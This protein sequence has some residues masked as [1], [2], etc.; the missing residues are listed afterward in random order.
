VS[1]DLIAC[2]ALVCSFVNVAAPVPGSY[3]LTVVKSAEPQS[4]QQFDFT[5]TGQADFQLNDPDNPST[6]FR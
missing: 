2:S 5:L 4:A 6:A 3:T 1:V